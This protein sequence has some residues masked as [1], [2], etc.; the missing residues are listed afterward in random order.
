MSSEEWEFLARIG[1]SKS[2]WKLIP[3]NLRELVK[4]LEA[5]EAITG[6]ELEQ[7]QETWVSKSPFMDSNGNSFVLYIRDRSFMEAWGR[8]RD[9]SNSNESTYKY[10]FKEC[11]TIKTMYG[12]QRGARYYAK[13]DLEDPLF[14]KAQSSHK[15]RLDVCWNCLQGFDFD[16]YP[17]FPRPSVKGFNM[18]DY[19]DYFAT[20]EVDPPELPHPTH[21]GYTGEYT[22]DW[23][24]VSKNYKSGKNWTCEKCKKDCIKCKHKFDCHHINGVKDDN[25][26]NNLM[27]LCRLCHSKEPQHSHLR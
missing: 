23:P 26:P 16:Q 27:A 12:D 14:S 1:A 2:K 19:F 8:F 25:N 22:K 11:R 9:K 21:Q 24:K 3:S 7:L 5:N 18:K 6:E 15:D 4:K 10:H 20:H 13:Y 17:D